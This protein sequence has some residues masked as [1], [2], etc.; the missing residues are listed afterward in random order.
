MYRYYQEAEVCYAYLEDVPSASEDPRSPDSHFRRSVWFKR[1]WTLQEL[2]AP[3]DVIFFDG[4]WVEIGT[5]IGL[6]GAVK[7]ITN[8]EEM[9][10]LKP[11]LIRETTIAR[12]MS[13][14]ATRQSTRI[15]DMAYSLMGIFNVN[16]PVIY[17]EGREA[18]TRLQLEII[19]TS[20]DH[21]IFAW[22]LPHVGGDGGMLASSP[23]YFKRGARLERIPYH[24][25]LGVRNASDL[26]SMSATPLEY[27]FPNVGLR[28][29]LHI[30]PIGD[31]GLFKAKLACKYRDS[32]DAVSVYLR[33]GRAL[34]MQIGTVYNRVSLP[35]VLNE[36]GV[37]F[38]FRQIYIAKWA[39]GLGQD[40]RR[41][42]VAAPYRGFFFDQGQELGLTDGFM[43][44]DRYPSNRVY[45]RR[46]NRDDAGLSLRSAVKLL[47][48]KSTEM[49]AVFFGTFKG[50]EWVDLSIPDR[51]DETAG[52]LFRAY[53]CNHGWDLMHRE[54]LDRHES[55]TATN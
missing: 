13:W 6:A 45:R 5:K 18:F 30:A 28:I 50:R 42:T 10:L 19:R 31:D 21:T 4:N 20:N 12:R 23:A 25:W 17:G 27:S 41:S 32:D 43:V 26:V 9:F 3:K 34:G 11:K 37:T 24:V 36:E 8:I 15:E 52:E 46:F 29:W 40:N 14:A 38:D 48:Y 7:S 44:V 54:R 55:A 22:E 1:G 33:S 49:V 2:L 47:D 35:P 53:Q 16:M 51:K 39:V